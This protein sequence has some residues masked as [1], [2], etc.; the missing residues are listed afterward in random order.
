MPFDK[1]YT[2][3][4]V[5]EILNVHPETVR[6]YIREGLLEAKVLG[7]RDR[8]QYRISEAQLR[9]YIEGTEG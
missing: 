2:A 5:A 6:R 8:P 4:E 1:L 9:R 7:K 3:N